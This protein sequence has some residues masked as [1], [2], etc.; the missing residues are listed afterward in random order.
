MTD[1]NTFMETLNAV[2]EIIRVAEEPLSQ[3][4]I[5][6]YFADLELEPNQQQLVLEFLSDSGNFEDTGEEV[7]DNSRI[8]QMYLEE[9]EM[10]PVYTS[11]EKEEC[12]RK[13]LN[14]DSAMVDT[15]STVWLENVL[16]T[17]RKYLDAQLNVEDLVQEGNMALLLKLRQ[18]CGSMVKTDVEEEL[19][20][21]VEEGV[22]AYVA[23][24]RDEKELG[25]AVIGRVSLVYEAIKLMTE[26]LG[27]S[28][29]TEELS[30]YTKIPAEELEELKDIIEEA[31]R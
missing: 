30:Q 26:E 28:P 29:T 25:D 7:S 17:A 27:H 14:G 24:A 18:L 5:L 1:Q 12:Y 9:L 4:E 2:K 31:N 3:E 21:A 19:S 13:L 22:I 15:I 20:T 10:L 8:F 11:E 6:A 23:A 16:R